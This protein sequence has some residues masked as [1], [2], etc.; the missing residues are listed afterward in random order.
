MDMHLAVRSYVFF[1]AVV[2]I[3]G[4]IVHVSTALAL[5]IP[6]TTTSASLSSKAFLAVWLLSCIITTSIAGRYQY[7]AIIFAG[8]SGG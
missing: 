5:I 4:C 8:I 1:C 7:P 3:D 6:A 2:L